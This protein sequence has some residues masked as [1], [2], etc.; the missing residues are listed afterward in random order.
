MILSLESNH[1]TEIMSYDQLMNLKN[2]EAI[3]MLSNS[4]ILITGGT[5]SLYAFVPM[6]LKN[7]IQKLLFT[8]GMK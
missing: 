7:I 8:L 3:I 1:Q 6:T 4:S 2:K 5:G